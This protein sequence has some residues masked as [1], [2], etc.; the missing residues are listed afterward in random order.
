MA[1]RIFRLV[2]TNAVQ[3]GTAP[4]YVALPL[5]ADQRQHLE[6]FVSGLDAGVDQNFARQGHVP[7]LGKKSE[8]ETRG[9]TETAF[10]VASPLFKEQFEIGGQFL[11]RWQKRK[12]CDA[13]KNSGW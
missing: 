9:H 11:A 6:Q 3:V 8:R 13:R 2:F 10:A 7:R 5:A 4:A 12:I 1:R